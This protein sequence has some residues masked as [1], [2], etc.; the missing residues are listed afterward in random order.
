MCA[1][2]G[3]G[4]TAN[5]MIIFCI[6]EGVFYMAQWEEYHTGTLQWSNGYIGVT[7]SQ[8]IQMGLF[9][10]TA[11]VGECSRLKHMVVFGVYSVVLLL[12]IYRYIFL[13]VKGRF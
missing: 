5:A 13:P 2:L 1:I 9:V 10:V 7:E 6:V 8:L 3:T 4:P 12:R 11:C